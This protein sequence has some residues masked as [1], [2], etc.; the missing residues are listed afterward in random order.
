MPECSSGVARRIGET[1]GP[2]PCVVLREILDHVPPHAAAHRF[3]SGRSAV[4]F[5]AAH[6]RRNVLIHLDL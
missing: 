4:T 5:A 1:F 2:Q 6:T 3:C